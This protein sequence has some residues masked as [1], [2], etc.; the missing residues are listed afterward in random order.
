MEFYKHGWFD[1]EELAALDQRSDWWKRFDHSQ[2]MPAVLKGNNVHLD[3]L[4]EQPLLNWL[5]AQVLMLEGAEKASTIGG[6]HDLYSRLF[7]HVLDRVHRKPEH[8]ATESTDIIKRA[9]L[10]R[11]LEEVAVA[12]WHGGGERAVPLP[13]VERRLE[14]AA[15]GGQLARLAEKRDDAL[16]SLLDSFFCRAHS[17]AEHRTVEFT[18]K[19]FGQFLTARRIAREIE[20]IHRRLKDGGDREDMLGC[21][22]RWLA[23]C[24][25]S[26]IDEDLLELLRGDC[27]ARLCGGPAARHRWVAS[28]TNPIVRGLCDQRYANARG[29]RPAI[30]DR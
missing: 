30:T 5:L 22:R 8:G 4:T 26:A 12:A 25:P 15:L 14:E 29:E 6:V 21:L 7:G 18:H 17:G 10:E 13:V 2:G 3:S 19:S 24:G 9:D 1:N 20:A 28:D 27:R 23:L 11:M 16:T